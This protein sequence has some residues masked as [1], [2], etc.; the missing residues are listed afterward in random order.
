MNSFSRRDDGE[1]SGKR[2]IGRE[3]GRT[4]DRNDYKVVGRLVRLVGDLVA[5][6]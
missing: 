2:N 5:R 6:D 4:R 3:G 1:T